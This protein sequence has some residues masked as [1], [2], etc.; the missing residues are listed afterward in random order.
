MPEANTNNP[1]LSHQSFLKMVGAHNVQINTLNERMLSTCATHL[2]Q[3]V[4]NI[5][6]LT[7]E[8]ASHY[9]DEG[10]SGSIENITL[11]LQDAQGNKTMLELG[12]K[13][14]IE[15]CDYEYLPCL[16]SIIEEIN[17]QGTDEDTLDDDQIMDN[18]AK[19]FGNRHHL[20]RITSMSDINHLFDVVT[21]T[22]E[23]A[24]ALDSDNERV[25]SHYFEAIDA[26]CEN[27]LEEAI[28]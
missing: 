16:K 5:C 18:A 4:P 6:E 15:N 20:S 9:N 8:N 7:W 12:D 21:S 24:I 25:G 14:D 22:I 17:E 27:K 13:G 19:L 3:L 1:M 2:Q 28:S 26:Q 11:H 23:Q 10:Y